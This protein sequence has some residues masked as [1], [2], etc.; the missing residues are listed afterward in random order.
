MARRTVVTMPGDGIGK[1]VLPEALRVLDAVGFERTTFTATS[2]GLLDHRGE[3]ASRQDHQA[4]RETTRSA[5]SEPSPPNRRTGG[6]RAFAGPRRQGAV[7]YSPSSAC[8]STFDLDICIRPCK[9]FPG[10]PPQL[11]PAQ[12]R[13]VRGARSVDVVIYRQNTECLYVGVE[14][15]N[16][17]EAVRKAFETHKKFAPF[18]NVPGEDLAISSRIF[19]RR[20]CYRICKAGFEH[21]K[22]YRVQ[23]PDGLRRSRTSSARRPGMM[24]QEAK[25]LAKEYNHLS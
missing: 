24:M 23:V 4:S 14:W 16:P 6:G 25:K 15:T 11:H 7:Y 21:A 18:K 2:G 1:V 19:T 3:R 5:S 8:A 22:K 12:E 10:N 20:A 17:P 9:S 13:W